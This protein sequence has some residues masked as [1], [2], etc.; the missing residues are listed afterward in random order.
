MKIA[1]KDVARIRALSETTCHVTQTNETATKDAIRHFVDGIG[2]PN[3]LWRDEHYA[4]GT[5]YRCLIAPPSFLN[6]I[7][8][9]LWD[10]DLPGIPRFDAGC[11]WEW[12][13]TIRVND[14]FTV[15]NTF[16]GMVAKKAEPVGERMFLQS[17]VLKYHNQMDKVVGTCRWSTIWTE[18]S[19][20]VQEFISEKH[21][22]T[23][24][25]LYTEEELE[26]IERGYA[27]E[28]IRGANPRYWEDVVVGEEIK[29]VVKGP[30]THADMVAFV[31]GIGYLGKAHALNPHRKEGY[32]VRQ[33]VDTGVIEPGEGVHFLDDVAR[34]ITGEPFAFNMGIQ[35]LC[36]LGHL[37]TN[38][39]GDDGFLKKLS[40]QF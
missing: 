31:G 14:T 3:P 28:E 34:S 40:A 8:P 5:R 33:N 36:W 21:K 29:P 23:Q 15:T 7:F 35:R 2:D 30:L 11:E 1:D 6:A 32:H 18:F 20:E 39:M 27:E 9:A 24:R 22:K 12:F 4:S 17:G 26:A 19:S 38:W 13:T 16:E 37:M 25:Y 10:K